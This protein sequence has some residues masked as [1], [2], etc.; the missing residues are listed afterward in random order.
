[1]IKDPKVLDEI[2]LDIFNKMKER[3]KA[4]RE[5][6]APLNMRVRN[7]DKDWKIEDLKKMKIELDKITS[8]PIRPKI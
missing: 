7:F 6:S 1:M 8:E 3:T 2:E 5:T 4:H